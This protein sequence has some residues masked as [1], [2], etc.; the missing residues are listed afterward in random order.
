MTSPK[1]IR[2]TITRGIHNG[3]T[4]LKTEYR[5][6]SYIL[7]RSQ[8]GW[9]LTTKRLALGRYNVGGRKRFQT[10]AEVQ[11]NCKAF[12]GVELTEAL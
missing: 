5:G 9:E 11:A 3:A 6:T 4:Y 7:R 10:L 1:Q 2:Q 12:A 8:W